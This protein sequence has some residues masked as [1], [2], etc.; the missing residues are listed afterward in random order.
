MP[1]SI[2]VV[3][4]VL[5]PFSQADSGCPSLSKGSPPRLDYSTYVGSHRPNAK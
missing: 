2:K 3:T 4:G 5:A 1:K